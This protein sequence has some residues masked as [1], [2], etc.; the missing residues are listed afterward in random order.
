M[1]IEF[2]RGSPGKVDSRTLNRETLRWTGRT[3]RGV[4][5]RR[6]ILC[7]QEAFKGNRPSKQLMAEEQH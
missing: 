7:P 2:Y 6:A 5:S 1:S 3:Y 4:D